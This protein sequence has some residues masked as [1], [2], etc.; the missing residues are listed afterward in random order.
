[1]KDLCTKKTFE[2]PLLLNKSPSISH[3]C[4]QSLLIWILKIICQLLMILC[5]LQWMMEYY[6]ISWMFWRL[7]I[8]LW[9]LVAPSLSLFLCFV[10]IPYV[11]W[12]SS[13]KIYWR[14]RTHCNWFEK[15]GTLVPSHSW[16][17][18]KVWFK[19]SRSSSLIWTWFHLPWFEDQVEWAPPC[20]LLS[21]YLSCSTRSHNLLRNCI[22][23]WSSWV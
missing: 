12:T 15:L 2:V 16:I 21:N 10:F 13:F 1:M 23:F 5:I 4:S 17:W 20:N 6:L 9:L 3:Y 8:S 19:V 7:D 22:C 14:W 11:D 18:Y